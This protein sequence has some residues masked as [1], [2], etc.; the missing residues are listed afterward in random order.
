MIHVHL[1]AAKIMTE[2][3]VHSHGEVAVPPTITHNS[4]SFSS[5][6]ADGKSSG[7]IMSS[8]SG[9][10]PR[11]EEYKLEY[12]GQH[13]VPPPSSD[14]VELID[15]LVSKFREVMSNSGMAHSKFRTKKRSFGSRFKTKTST[16][17]LPSLESVDSDLSAGS[18][19]SLGEAG[20]QAVSLDSQDV[21]CILTPASP[22]LHESCTQPEPLSASL[23]DP[24]DFHS[25][26]HQNILPV[27]DGRSRTESSD[28]D[29]IPELANLKSS[30]EFQ[31][32]SLQDGSGGE[33]VVKNQ[34]VRLIFTGV[35]VLVVTSGNT[36]NVVLKKPIRQIAC[37]AQ[38]S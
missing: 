28:F 31:A 19:D 30:T 23:E 32:L 22:V 8:L 38:V 7:Y 24:A 12:W 20:R 25:S 1:Q 36:E 4:N 5:L 10:L 17:K 14:Q 13:Q 16:P 34:K 27:V 9:S 29:T 15:D 2:F 37:C 18:V 33:M 3:K 35:S 11:E 21:G 6:P 26:C